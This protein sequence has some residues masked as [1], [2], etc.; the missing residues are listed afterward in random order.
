MIELTEGTVASLAR[1]THACLIYDRAEEAIATVV[2]Y[3]VAG[4]E[5]GECCVWVVGEHGEQPVRHALMAAGVPVED[6]CA[7][8][9]LAIVSQWEVSFPDGH[10]DPAAMIHY[11]RE[12]IVSAVAG[13]FRGLRVVAEM[14]WA[15]QMG[16]GFDRLVHYEALGNHLYPDEPLVAVC[17][18]DRSRFPAAV[19]HDAL[20][21]HPVVALGDAL[22]ANPYYELPDAVLEGLEA[23]RRLDWLL[24]QLQRSR[25]GER[26]R[27]A[28]LHAQAA[29]AEAEAAVRA[30]DE[31]IA[32]AA[33][34]LR[35]PITGLRGFT[36]LAL[37]RIGR[38]ASPDPAVLRDNLA[39][40]ERQ[41]MR[42]ER[43]VNQLLDASRLGTG[44]LE[45]AF[46]STDLA[47]LVHDLAVDVDFTS[48]DHRILVRAPKVLDAEVDPWRF[49]Q[50]VRNLLD[51]AVKYSPDGGTIEVEL[52][53][54]RSE[55]VRLAV[56]DHGIGIPPEHRARIFERYYR[57]HQSFGGMGLGLYLCSAIV[58]LHGGTISAEFPEDGG[59]RFVVVVPRRR[60]RPP[61]LNGAAHPGLVDGTV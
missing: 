5:A 56:R 32:I 42:L 26:Q 11:V 21:T 35:T 17:M 55:T 12:S 52:A 46:D 13:G 2:P 47:R 19:C 36:Q 43:M 24:E 27:V 6:A 37:R 14:S 41:S 4:L 39:M 29:Q 28:L 34:D 60:A 31:F 1:G 10:F 18:Y 3:V 44:T 38:S 9:A 30:R 54:T 20:R 58:R 22:Y 45:L 8:G 16:V 23:D 7:R 53:S 33:H 15:L 51:N 50:V 61:G 40:I 57:G 48:S 49:E 59:T 25:E